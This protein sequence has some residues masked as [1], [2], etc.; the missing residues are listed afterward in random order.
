MLNCSAA[1]LNFDLPILSKSLDLP[2]KHQHDKTPSKIIHKW[3]RLQII[4]EFVVVIGHTLCIHKL[5]TLYMRPKEDLELFLSS[6]P[7]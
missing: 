6:E 3:A 1:I 7:P 4:R 2:L 5:Q